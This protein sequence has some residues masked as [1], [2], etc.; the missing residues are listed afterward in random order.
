MIR[1]LPFL[2]LLAACSPPASTDCDLRNPRTGDRARE[3][4]LAAFAD[5]GIVA[6]GA[7]ECD[8]ASCVRDATV[9][10]L[11]ADRIAQGYC[12]PGCDPRQTSTCADG[13]T[14]TPFA[15]FGLCLRAQ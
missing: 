15:D 13:R 5:G 1:S 6:S 2:L 11:G 10:S 9:P 8:A 14:C 7:A 3:G 12:A 4:E